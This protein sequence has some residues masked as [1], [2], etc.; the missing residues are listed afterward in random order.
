LLKKGLEEGEDLD[1]PGKE[2]LKEK[3][4]RKK[5]KVGNYY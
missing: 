3:T 5:K 2:R 4:F 1:F